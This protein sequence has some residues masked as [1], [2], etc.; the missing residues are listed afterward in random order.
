MG[1]EQQMKF[2]FSR[3]KKLEI[4]KEY[5]I[6]ATDENLEKIEEKDGKWYFN[7][8]PLEEI[9]DLYSEKDKNY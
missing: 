4:A 8:I 2:D 1:I 6:I 9:N 5:K 3:T 7:D